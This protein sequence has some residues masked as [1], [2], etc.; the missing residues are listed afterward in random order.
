[1]ECISGIEVSLEHVRECGIIC[2]TSRSADSS[3]LFLIFFSLSSRVSFHGFVFER[4]RGMEDEENE[5]G[6]KYLG[7]GYW[8]LGPI[9][10]KQA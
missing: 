5:E 4:M 10:L 1:M 9:S 6:F 8:A 2:M 7:V 3:S